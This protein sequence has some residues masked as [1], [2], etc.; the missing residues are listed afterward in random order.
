MSSPLEHR[1]EVARTLL[2]TRMVRMER[3]DKAV[4]ALATLRRWGSSSAAAYAISAIRYPERLAIVDERGTLTFAEVHARTNALARALR[5]AGVGEQDGVALMCRNHRGYIEATVAC[6]KLGASVL[7]LNT[8]FAGPQIADVLRREAPVALIY[9][10]EFADLVREGS[11]EM[12]RF[13]SWREPRGRSTAAGQG[14]PPGE[15]GASADPQAGTAGS[16]QG[17]GA[18]REDPW[19]EEL[20]AHTDNSP[21]QPPV[22][23]GRVVILTSGTTG[24][25]KGAKRKQPDSLEPAAA[26]LSKI[27]LKAREITVIAAPMFHSWG[28]GHFT[29]ALPLA[30]TLVLRR[31]FDPEQTLA[32]VARHRATALAVVPV[33]LQRIMELPAGDA[34]NATTHRRCGSSRR[35]ARCSPASWPRG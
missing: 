3:P 26:M 14:G 31:R 20:I 30:S 9:D 34:S 19:V 12:R 18:R 24:T 6:A 22:E 23:T 16:P 32:D 4:R 29:L 25:P 1:L 35:P 8:A 11:E 21:L 15:A 28:Y 7:Y 5:A 33:M 27:P 17:N 2:G 10:E 13:V